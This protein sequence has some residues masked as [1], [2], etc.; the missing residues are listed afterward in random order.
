MCLYYLVNIIL[1]LKTFEVHLTQLKIVLKFIQE[2]GLV[3]N[4]KKCLFAAQDV[5][6]LNDLITG[7]GI[8]PDPGKMKA[9]SNIPIPKNAHDV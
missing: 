5:K 9:V 8:H 2:A 1:F 6:I 3:F 7:N 4:P